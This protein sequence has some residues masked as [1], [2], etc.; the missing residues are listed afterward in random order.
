MVAEGYLRKTEGTSESGAKINVYSLGELSQFELY[1]SPPI[2]LVPF[3]KNLFVSLSAFVTH[4]LPSAT[5]T[6]TIHAGQRALV[7]LGIASIVE[8]I[9]Q[10]YISHNQMVDAHRKVWRKNMEKKIKSEVAMKQ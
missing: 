3:R 8:F 9:E 7:E 1:P 6:P 2:V 5:T 10:I 4:P